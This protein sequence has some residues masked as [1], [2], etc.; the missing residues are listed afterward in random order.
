[1]FLPDNLDLVQPKSLCSFQHKDLHDLGICIWKLR[2][3]TIVLSLCYLCLTSNL[4][5]KIID[6]QLFQRNCFWCVHSNYYCFLIFQQPTIPLLYQADIGRC[7]CKISSVFD[8]SEYFLGQTWIEMLEKNSMRWTFAET[9]SPLVL[10]ICWLTQT[11]AHNVAFCQN[12]LFCC[13]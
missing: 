4:I 3:R 10:F 8:E 13:S 5:N 11:C 2:D 6:F 12:F 9:W 7:K 1:M